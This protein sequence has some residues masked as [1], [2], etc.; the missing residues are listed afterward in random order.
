[1]REYEI[2]RKRKGRN[3]MRDEVRKGKERYCLFNE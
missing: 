2:V 3:E 1:M